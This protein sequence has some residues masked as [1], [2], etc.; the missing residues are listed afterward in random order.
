VA[1]LVLAAIAVTGSGCAAVSYRV[2]GTE[3]QRLV[4]VAPP[5]R[6]VEVRVVPRTA[7]LSPAVARRP[8]PPPPAAYAAAPPPPPGG[9]DPAA[10]PAPPPPPPAGFDPAAVAPPPPPAAYATEPPPYDP[11]PDATL[12]VDVGVDAPPPVVVRGP[13]VRVRPA[14]VYVAP[15]VAARPPRVAT[16]VV[17]VPGGGGGLRGAPVAPA[18]RGSPV[19]GGGGGWRGAPVVAAAR[20]RVG[21]AVFGG[22]RGGFHSSGRSL[23]GRGGGGGS[24]SAAAVAVG[25]V[26]VVGLVAAL[27][28]AADHA[29]RVEQAKNYNGWIRVAPTHPVH[30]HYGGDRQRVVPLS[31][32]QEVDTLG[33]QYAVIRASE[34]TV[35][36]LGPSA[37]R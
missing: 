1:A 26:A 14:P 31:E 25:V 35:Q 28:V 10:P 13:V 11:G 30:L 3:V 22:S 6:G 34:G 9:F 4:Q 21:P 5:E 20:P 19:A 16:T 8:P 32:I 7:P 17:V 36:H 23:G 29:D 18:L 24:G 12:E 15:P 27:A 33:L 37:P 2:P